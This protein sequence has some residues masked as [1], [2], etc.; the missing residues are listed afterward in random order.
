MGE[1]N[2]GKKHGTN[3]FG[4]LYFDLGRFLSLDDGDES[5]FDDTQGNRQVHIYFSIH[6]I[7]CPTNT[8]FIL[9][10]GPIFLCLDFDRFRFLILED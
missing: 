6:P 8:R 5:S 1:R 9:K 4:P 2:R 10:V 7:G 3:E